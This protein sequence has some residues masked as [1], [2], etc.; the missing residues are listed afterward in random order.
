MLDVVIGI[1][2]CRR[3]DG[4]LNLL[5]HIAELEFSGSCAVVVID[6]DLKMQGRQVCNA[7]TDYRWPTETI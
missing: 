4:L 3:P 7:L 2:T 5:D 1:C 6:N